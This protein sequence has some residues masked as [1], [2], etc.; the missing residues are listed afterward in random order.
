MIGGGLGEPSSR[1]RPRL[2]PDKEI[3]IV[4]RNT[5]LRMEGPGWRWACWGNHRAVK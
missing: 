4:T 3:E 1:G 2:L 5:A